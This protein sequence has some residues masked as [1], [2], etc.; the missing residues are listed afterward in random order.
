MDIPI[1]ALQSFCVLAEELHFGNAAKR[2]RISPPSLSQQISRL[3]SQL[4]GRA[5]VHRPRRVVLTASGVQLLP[6]ATE[7][8]DAHRAVL[9]WARKHGGGEEP[10]LRVGV[11]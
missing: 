7:A 2:L 4:G 6:L 5:F 1:T 3:E 8:R 9:D 11:V 10:L